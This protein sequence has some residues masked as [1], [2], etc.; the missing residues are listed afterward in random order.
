MK[1]TVRDHLLQINQIQ[2][3]K[4]KISNLLSRNNDPGVST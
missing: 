3:E 1:K 4:S 2:N